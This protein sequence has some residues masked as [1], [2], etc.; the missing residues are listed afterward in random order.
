MTPISSKWTFFYKKAFPVFWFGFI[1][2][3]VGTTLMSGAAKKDVMFLVVPLIMAVFGFIMF[4]KLLWDLADEVLDGGD[5]LK[6]R[7]GGYEEQ[8]PLSDIMNVNA[9]MMINPQRITLRLV[10][11]G[12]FGNE[13][14]FLPR[15]SFTLNPFAKS[16]IAEDLIVRVD[17]A[18]SRRA[19]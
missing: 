9:S 3:F 2:I 17:R 19:S 4:R 6:V 15:R 5:L 14:S 10:Q 1:A 16:Q 7:K 13:I 11:P 18:R 12:R 8:V